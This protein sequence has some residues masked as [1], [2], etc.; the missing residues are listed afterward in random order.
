MIFIYVKD[1]NRAEKKLKLCVVNQVRI[2]NPITYEPHWGAL[3]GN[4]I[5]NAQC[6]SKQKTKSE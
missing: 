5:D 6:L 4:G 3:F 1:S 2:I